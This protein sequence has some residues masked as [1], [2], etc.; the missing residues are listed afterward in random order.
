LF[1]A[2]DARGVWN[3]I[4]PGHQ[5]E[6]GRVR[7]VAGDVPVLGGDHSGPRRPNPVAELDALGRPGRPIKFADYEKR[8]AAIEKRLETILGD[9]A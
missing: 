8:L 3:Q 9:K 1:K 7:P 2:A 5:F 6:N 4:L